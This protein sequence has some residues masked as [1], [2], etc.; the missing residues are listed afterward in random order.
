MKR[1]MGGVG[2]VSQRG[3]ASRGNRPGIFLNQVGGVSTG[4]SPTT[5]SWLGLV[6]RRKDRGFTI[7]TPTF[8]G[9]RPSNNALH[10]T[11]V[12]TFRCTP[13]AGERE[14]STAVDVQ[15]AT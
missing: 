3:D 14:C 5:A 4:S 11:K 15:T 8:I 1:K 6:K 9:W 10:L 2:Q 13:F 12:A 7:G